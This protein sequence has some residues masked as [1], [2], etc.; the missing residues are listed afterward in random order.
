MRT[1][2]DQARTRRTATTAAPPPAADG[3]PSGAVKFWALVGLV[4]IG[5]IVSGW[6]RWALSAD[7]TPVPRGPDRLPTDDLLAL[8]LL[9]AASGVLMAVLVW[10]CVVRPIRREGRLS[11]DGKLLLAGMLGYFV[12]QLLNVY[13]TAFTF[14]AY[15]F[16]RGSW[17]NFFPGMKAPDQGRAAEGLLWAWCMFTY[18]VALAAMVGSRLLRILE[19]RLPRM[20]R[21]GLWAT[22]FGIFFVADMAIE[23]PLFVGHQIYA[24]AGVPAS[25]S[26]FAGKPY[27]FPMFE[28]FLVGF[29]CLGATW[30]RE[31]RDGQGRSFVERGL[32]DL[33]LGARLKGLV[34]FTAITGYAVSL[35]ALTYFLPF[36]WLSMQA[37]TYPSLPSYLRGNAFCGTPETGRPCPSQLVEEFSP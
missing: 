1:L 21:A 17:G 9:E 11:F 19:R 27:Q 31:S 2:D 22:L 15:A 23:I 12:D 24:Y 36:S 13:N 32:D 29:V 35:L 28:P 20:S 4:A 7:F 25:I 3:R 26:L 34:S 10:R 33:R 8:R 14:N 6:L 16:N 37:D 18:F 30:L 5:F